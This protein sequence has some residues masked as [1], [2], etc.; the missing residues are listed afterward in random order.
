MY[1]TLSIQVLI[2]NKY[3]YVFLWI[4][5]EDSLPLFIKKGIEYLE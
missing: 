2:V 1:L 3:G 4:C 5:F